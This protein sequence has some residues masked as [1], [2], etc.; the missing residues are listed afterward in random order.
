[1]RSQ[2]EQRLI[3]SGLYFLKIQ[4]GSSKENRGGEIQTGG[5][6]ATENLLSESRPFIRKVRGTATEVEEREQMLGAEL[7][8]VSGGL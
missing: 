6:K 8:T 3:N 7:I 5:K 4:A 2:D 1:M